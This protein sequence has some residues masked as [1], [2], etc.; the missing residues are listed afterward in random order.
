MPDDDGP[1]AVRMT[2]GKVTDASTV[3][4][5]IGVTLGGGDVE[6]SL[7]FFEFY[8]PTLNDIVYVLVIGPDKLVLGHLAT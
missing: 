2:R 6:V 8:T 4:G 5:V 1:T 7:P 3:G